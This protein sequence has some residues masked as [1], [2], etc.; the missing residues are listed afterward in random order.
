MTTGATGGLVTE[1]TVTDPYRY[2]LGFGNHHASEAIPGALP[3]YGTNLPQ[4]H[5]YGLYAEHLNGTS[6]ISSRESVSN[7]WLYRERPAAPHGPVRPVQHES[8]SS[9]LPTNQAVS[10]TP[11]PHTWGPL[12]PPQPSPRSAPEQAEAGV[13]FVEGLKTIGGNGDA[14]LREGLAVH[15]YTFTCDMH[16]RAFVNHDGEL[17]L[18]PQSGTLDIKTELGSLRV[19]PGMIAVLPVGIRYSVSIVASE[20]SG[21]QKRASGYALE[22]FGTRFALPELGVLGANGLAHVRDFEYPVAAFDF[23]PPATTSPAAGGPWE[24]TVKLS[25]RFFSYTQPHTPF[26]VVAWHGR[27][28]PYRYDLARFTHLTSNADQLDPTAFCV[29]TAPSKWPGV[30]AVD[31]CVFGEKWLVSKDTLRIPYYHRTMATE[32]CGV[33]HGAYGG[34]IRRLEPGGLSFEQ[35]FMPHGETY[36]AYRG[37]VDEAAGSRGPVTV[38]KDYLG[39]MFHVSAPLGL[40]KWATQYHPDIR[41]ERPGLWDSFRSHLLDHVEDIN[42]H[43]SRAGM[44]AFVE[45][46]TATLTPPASPRGAAVESG[47]GKVPESRDIIAS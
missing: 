44:A 3:G 39:F 23:E 46:A 32:L 1:P 38:A 35:S 21:D 43:L 9:F 6:F 33:I 12:P 4:K 18:I 29:L 13:G 36:E 17:L 20:T 42:E 41:F 30:S 7:V 15:Q 5:K 34:S 28:A 11:L 25:G 27:H 45:S 2:Q 8:E 26:D 40:T 22:I 24:I 10:F 14:T 37:D 31:F 16:R 47:D 19:S